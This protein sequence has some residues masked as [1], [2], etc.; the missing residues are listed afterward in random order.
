MNDKKVLIFD[1]DGTIADSGMKVYEIL[2]EILPLFGIRKVKESEIERFRGM[3]AR[4]LLKEFN[5]PIYKVP[6]IFY[7]FEKEYQKIIKDMKPIDG[8]PQVL[9]KLHE[10]G[11]GLHIASSN[12]AESIGI[13][14]DA[15]KIEYFDLVKGNSGMLGK[16]RII[17]KII[18]EKKLLFE[19][20]IYV[21][22]EIRDIES[23]HRVGIKSAAVTWGFNTKKALK[24]YEPDY[25]LS[26]PEELLLL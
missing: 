7:Q 9:K 12:S 21:G 15:N 22:D 25:L 2:N 10:K 20:V 19:S 6:L 8:V 23:A 3:N 17:K 13:F 24:E 4:D 18:N 11:I 5:V 16:S 1:F 26:K 14:L